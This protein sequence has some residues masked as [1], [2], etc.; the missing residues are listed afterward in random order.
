MRLPGSDAQHQGLGCPVTV[1]CIALPWPCG[2]H[3]ETAY[4]PPPPTPAASAGS[5]STGKLRTSLS[6]HSAYLVPTPWLSGVRPRSFPPHARPPAGPPG[7][8]GRLQ[9]LPPSTLPLKP[10]THA[11]PYTSPAHHTLNLHHL[12]TPRP[13]LAPRVHT[14]RSA[15]VGPR[16]GSEVCLAAGPAAA[17]VGG[18][19]R[20]R[21]GGGVGGRHQRLVDDVQDGLRG[22]GVGGG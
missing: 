10:P 21:R 6:T 15:F 13:A 7:C 8:W 11:T 3:F 16:G 19:L 17:L 18:G 14:C 20:L 9:R 22:W 1:Q 5:C 12:P 2:H 4:L